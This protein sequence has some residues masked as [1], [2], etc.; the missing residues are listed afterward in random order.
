MGRTVGIF[1]YICYKNQPNVG[2]YTIHGSYGILETSMEH[3][4]T[5][6]VS[7]IS[8]KCLSPEI[9]VNLSGQVYLP[10][11]KT[12]ISPENWWLED[13]IVLS[14]MVPFQGRHVNF[15]GVV[16]ST[17]RETTSPVKH[18]KNNNNNNNNN[19]NLLQPWY[20]GSL[21]FT[22]ICRISS[23]LNR[24]FHGNWPRDFRPFDTFK[25]VT[26]NMLGGRK[27]GKIPSY[28]SWWLN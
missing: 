18:K 9:S 15:H 12:N 1:T 14:R 6:F 28:T 7:S 19:N 21:P 26:C 10:P 11:W 16:I 25:L 23:H 17:T 13:S 3:H 22:E 20:L 2:K 5:I 8:M 27:G 4:Q 24:G